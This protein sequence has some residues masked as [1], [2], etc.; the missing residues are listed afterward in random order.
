MG[1]DADVHAGRSSSRRV[2]VIEVDDRED[3]QMATLEGLADEQFKLSYRGQSHGFT[4]V[5]KVGAVGYLFMGN[6]RPDQ[7]FVMGLE[8]PDDRKKFNNQEP[9]EST[10]YGGADQQVKHDKDGNTHIKTPGG[11][12]YINCA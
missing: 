4:S 1:W 7:A 12:V 9:G 5:P 8:H 10:H 6:G 3:I 11:I 2:K